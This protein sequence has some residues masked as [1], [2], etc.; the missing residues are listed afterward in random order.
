MG[1]SWGMA[2][3]SLADL[4]ARWPARSNAA[5]RSGASSEGEDSLLFEA[6]LAD[7]VG[8]GD[9]CQYP[10]AHSASDCVDRESELG[11][12]AFRTVIAVMDAEKFRI[13][14]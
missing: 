11:R 3:G 10:L 8:D 1:T 4:S 2:G 6:A 9:V 14:G 12:Q 13:M 7:P 5:V